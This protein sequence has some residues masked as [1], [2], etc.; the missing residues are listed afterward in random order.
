MTAV[1][2]KLIVCHLLPFNWVFNQN[3]WV[4]KI[5]MR[6]W[7]EVTTHVLVQFWAV[8]QKR[9]GK[10]YMYCRIEIF[11]YMHMLQNCVLFCAFC[12]CVTL[13]F[14]SHCGVAPLV[15]LL[16]SSS[17][18]VRCSATST[19]AILAADGPTA[20]ALCQV[21]SEPCNCIRN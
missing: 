19:V 2:L 5:L 1:K 13:Q 17:Q 16:S 4:K 8:G 14:V 20:D 12:H 11:M 6:D 18:P 7:G 21:G 10:H 15:A 9:L 3:K